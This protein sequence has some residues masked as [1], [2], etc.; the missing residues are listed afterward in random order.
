MNKPINRRNK[1]IYED[2]QDL[3]FKKM[4]RDEVIWVELGDKYFLKPQSIYRVI[5]NQRSE[6]QKSQPELPLQT[7]ETNG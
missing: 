3:Y 2:Y 7:L 6:A 1:L 5:L 4:M